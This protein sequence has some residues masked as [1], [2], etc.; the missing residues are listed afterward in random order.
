MLLHDRVEG[1]T[2]E[3]GHTQV[4]Q[5]HIVALRAELGQRMLPIVR[6]VHRVA[7]PLQKP[8][9]CVDKARLIINQQNLCR[10]VHTTIPR[11]ALRA[12]ALSAVLPC[13]YDDAPARS[14]C[15]YAS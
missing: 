5:D 6:R 7:I 4:T 15:R 2:V 3:G 14:A 13:A 12:Q 9:Q 1:G 10:R 8:G 11:S